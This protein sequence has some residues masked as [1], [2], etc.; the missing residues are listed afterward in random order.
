MPGILHPHQVRG[1]DSLHIRCAAAPEIIAFDARGELAIVGFRLDHVEVTG[2]QNLPLTPSPSRPERASGV[3]VGLGGLGQGK[4]AYTAGYFPSK[5]A[6]LKPVPAQVIIDKGPRAMDFVQAFVRAGGDR[7]DA[8]QLLGKVEDFAG[9]IGIGHFDH[10][11]CSTRA[12]SHRRVWES[13]AHRSRPRWRNS[14]ILADSSPSEPYSAAMLFHIRLDLRLTLQVQFA[15]RRPAGL[16]RCAQFHA[17][18]GRAFFR[19]CCARRLAIST[20]GVRS[21]HKPKASASG[22]SSSSVHFRNSRMAIGLPVNGFSISARSP[23]LGGKL[24]V[25]AGAGDVLAVI[26]EGARKLR[27]GV[28]A[29]QQEMLEASGWQCPRPG[30]LPPSSVRTSTR[31]IGRLMRAIRFCFS[32]WRA[33]SSAGAASPDGIQAAGVQVRELV[34]GRRDEPL[35]R[36]GKR[37]GADGRPVVV[38]KAHAA[39]HEVI[40]DLQVILVGAIQVGQV[41]L[42]RIGEGQVA[43]RIELGQHHHGATI[44]GP[45]PAAGWRRWWQ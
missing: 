25:G 24:F 32:I 44:R 23:M 19:R 28:E 3:R 20:S 18:G 14:L 5:Y 31:P 42:G 36:L 35:D 21:S 40:G 41:D 43:D 38:A 34:A 4:R 1:D 37:A 11:A 10:H 30:G 7:W 9:L 16:H 13:R 29:E 22:C 6:R 8:D 15:S 39:P 17:A 27:V 26:A 45:A 12:E 33:I 2:E